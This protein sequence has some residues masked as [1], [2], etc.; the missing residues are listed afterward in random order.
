MA[1]SPD[2][3]GAAR[4]F[5]PDPLPPMPWFGMDIGG[6]LSKLVYFEPTDPSSVEEEDRV[7]NLRR[8]L[9][10]N[11]SYGDSG[12][13]DEAKQMEDVVIMQRKGRLHFIRFPTA[14][15]TAF[16]E[17]AKAKGMA[18]TLST[19]CATGGG[20]HKFEADIRRELNMSLH[21]FDELDSLVGGVEFVEGANPRELYYWQDPA[22]DSLASKQTYDFAS[23]YPFLLVN[24][25]SG[26]SILA[27]RGP[28]EHARVSGTSLG[29]GTFL[30]LCCLLTQCSTFEQALQLAARGDNKRVDKLVRDIYGGDYDRFGLSGDIV[31]S[32]FGQMN[33]QERA[34]G[35]SRE[36]LARATLMMITNNIGALAR[37]C[38]KSEGTERCVFVGNFLRINTIAMRSLS[39]AMEYWSNGTMKA[40][41]CEHE[42]GRGATFHSVIKTD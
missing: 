20:A 11:L 3:S 27:V 23:P 37:L 22:D 32:S 29:G 9:T 34:E 30:G 6:T 33:V 15:M 13:R 42:V 24:I 4:E 5:G 10:N 35:V 2:S 21:K 40:L 16:L 1:H 14:H 26:V 38:C 17:L 8:Y 31:A 18:E 19:V 39:T 12:H 41:F 7:R 25:G 36:D 28:G